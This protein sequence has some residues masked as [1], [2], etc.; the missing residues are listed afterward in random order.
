V[1]SSVGRLHTSEL[2]VSASTVALFIVVVAV[3][4]RWT[5]Y[6]QRIQA[7]RAF[8]PAQLG[9]WVPPLPSPSEFRTV[10][11]RRLE[12]TGRALT[13]FGLL[14]MWYAAIR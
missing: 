7:P 8:S 11:A 9:W 2:T 6:R 3:A 12:V 13:Y 4:C 10:A 14:A 1:N 5:A